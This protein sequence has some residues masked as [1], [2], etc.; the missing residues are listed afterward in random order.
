[1]SEKMD[2]FAQWLI[3]NE[4]KK[5]TED[6]ETIASAFKEMQKEQK[7]IEDKTLKPPEFVKKIGRP[8]WQ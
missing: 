1:M 8:E 4:D 2:R 6:F 7:E 3:D 5:G